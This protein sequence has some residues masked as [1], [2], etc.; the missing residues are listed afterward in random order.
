[1]AHMRIFS[2]SITSITYFSEAAKKDIPMFW[3]WFVNKLSLRFLASKQ[4]FR[5]LNEVGYKWLRKTIKYMQ[6]DSPS[7][8]GK[9][10]HVCM[11]HDEV[12]PNHLI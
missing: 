7:H 4:V 10:L 11:V 8:L 1:M 2:L 5:M 12:Y 3:V 6:N 9:R